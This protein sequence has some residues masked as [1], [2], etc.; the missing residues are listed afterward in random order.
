MKSSACA[1]VLPPLDT[2]ARA[3]LL[4]DDALHALQEAFT[5]IPDPRSRHGV[6]Y[7][8]AFLLTCLVAALLCN[9]NSLAAV[10]QWCAGQQS[11]LQEVFGARR[12]STPT[13]ALYRWLLPRL[14]AEHVE[15][16][17][18]SWVQAT[19]QAAVD[20]P[21]VADG[22][23]VRGATDGGAALHLLSFSTVQTQETVLQIRVDTKT[24]DIPMVQEMLPYVPVAGRVFLADALHTQRATAAQ[25]RALGADYVFT[26]GVS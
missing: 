11:V 9:C 6:R 1:V 24:N 16:V 8:L 26:E 18:A 15:W 7:D 5:T 3:T 23:T 21:L 2:D 14:V 25:V 19:L 17:L 22:K 4:A 12:H 20:D 13:A 10:G